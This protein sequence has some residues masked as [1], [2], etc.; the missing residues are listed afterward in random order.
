MPHPMAAS[1]TPSPSVP[2]ESHPPASLFR[3]ALLSARGTSPAGN[4]WGGDVLSKPP[5]FPWGCSSPRPCA[6]ARLPTRRSCEPCS[7]AGRTTATCCVPTPPWLLTTTTHS[8]TGKD[9][10]GQEHHVSFRSCC[11]ARLGF[12]SVKEFS[13][14]SFPFQHAPVLL[15]SSVCSQIS[16]RRAPSWA[17]SPAPP[18]NHRLN[19]NGDQ[20]HPAGAGAGLG[21]GAPGADQSRGTAVGGTG[22]SVSPT[23][24]RG[25]RRA[26]SHPDLSYQSTAGRCL[27]GLIFHSQESPV[28]H[29]ERSLQ[30]PCKELLAETRF[31][32][33]LC[34]IFHNVSSEELCNCI[35]FFLHILKN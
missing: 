7:A 20:V 4:A 22:G 11:I 25:H 17:G 28:L 5:R 15:S 24:T 34:R 14:F 2:S 6:H 33:E 29:W 9:R 10:H 27:P 3:T 30:S 16:G 13:C 23:R 18:R 19:G 1:L 32:I 8:W 12:A 21:T 31:A 26:G 35:L